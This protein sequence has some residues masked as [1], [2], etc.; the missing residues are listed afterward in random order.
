MVGTPERGP[1]NP[2]LLVGIRARAQCC[3][4]SGAAYVTIHQWQKIALEKTIHIM[5]P[6][7]ATPTWQETGRSANTV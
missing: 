3:I 4:I 6:P 1:S 2:Y 7:Q 5:S